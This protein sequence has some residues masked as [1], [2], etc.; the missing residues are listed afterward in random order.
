MRMVAYP[1]PDQQIGPAG[2]HAHLLD[3]RQF[4]DR[5]DDRPQ[6]QPGPGADRQV[7]HH[8]AAER[9]PV[10]FCPEP[11]IT[12]ARSS[13][14]SRPAIAGGDA[15]TARASARC[16][17]LASDA[18]ALSSA[19]SRSPASTAAT[20]GATTSAAPDPAIPAPVVVIREA[21][22]RR[23]SAKPATPNLTVI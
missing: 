7:D 15:P 1:E 5:P 23:A 4:A 17:R 20:S 8:R 14:A 3:L 6:A 2:D 16:D 21:S 19:K 11:W 12:P 18:S 13:R 10:N 9:R 22:R